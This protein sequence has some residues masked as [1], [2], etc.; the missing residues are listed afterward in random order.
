LCEG[1]FQ[2]LETAHKHQNNEKIETKIDEEE[3]KT[4]GDEDDDDDAD[5]E[6]DDNESEQPANAEL[7]KL[8]ILKVERF[9]FPITGDVP[10]LAM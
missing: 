10:C 3:D 2:V 6:A 9:Q 5:K 7:L 4:K 8:V 1:R